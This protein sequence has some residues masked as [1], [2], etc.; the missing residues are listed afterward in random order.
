MKTLILKFSEIPSFLII[1]NM[2]IGFDLDRVLINYPP[3]LPSRVLDRL[4][5]ER[6]N[7]ILIYRIP[8]YPEQWMRKSIHFPLLRQPIK[9]NLSF[10]RSIPKDT[11]K[12]YLISSRY[13]FL[14]KITERLVKRYDLDKIFDELYFNFENKQP[15]TF[16]SALIKKL[17]LDVY[18]DDDLSL[19]RHAAKD[20][21]ATTFFWLNYSGQKNP[22]AKNIFAI[23]KL[24]EIFQDV[25]LKIHDVRK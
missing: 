3:F 1:L 8:T 12:L 2:N 24:S 25:S 14:Q 6:D 20:N 9:E 10:L 17:K 7:G 15:H 5:K 13:K 22:V 11:N 18:V 19:I 23:T 16:K 21:P 4:Y